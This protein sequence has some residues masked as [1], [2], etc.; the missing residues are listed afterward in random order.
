VP[1]SYT[2][3]GEKDAVMYLVMTYAQDMA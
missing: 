1:H 3:A 2:N